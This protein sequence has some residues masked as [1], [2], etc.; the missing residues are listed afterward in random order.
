MTTIKNAIPLSTDLGTTLFTSVAANTLVTPVTPM[1]PDLSSK[2]DTGRSNLDNI[3]NA[4]ALTFSGKA[5]SKA[6][7]HLLVNGKDV[8]ALTG[9]QI[10]ADANGAWSFTD[11]KGTV[12]QNNNV[13]Q[14]NTMTEIAGSMS[15][16]SPTLKVTVDRQKPVLKVADLV[17]A[18]DSGFSSSDD[19]TN[20]VATTFTGVSEAGAVVNLYEMVA[21]K[22]N[23]ISLASVTA[24]ANGIWTAKLDGKM[25]LSEGT[26]QIVT[27]STDV[28]G[29]VSDFSPALKLSIDRT[30]PATLLAPQLDASAQVPNASNTTWQSQPVFSGKAQA[31]D[32]ITLIDVDNGSLLGKAIVQA[33][34]AWKIQSSALSL[35][36]HHLVAYATDLAG[37]VSS[38]SEMSTIQVSAP[39]L[40]A[41]STPA[42]MAKYDSGISQ[43]DNITNFNQLFF[44]A[45][46]APG[47]TVR[48]YES[49][50][51]GEIEIGVD[52]ANSFGEVDIYSTVL[53]EGKHIIYARS[54]DGKQ[55]STKSDSMVMTVDTKVSDFSLRMDAASDNGKSNSDGIT[56]VAQPT[57]SGT[58][59]AY[60]YVEL[61]E[62]L[63]KGQTVSLGQTKADA[64][65]NWSLTPSVPLAHGV[66]H[67]TG[68]ATDVAGNTTLAS[69]DIELKLYDLKVYVDLN[70]NFDSGVSNQDHVTNSSLLQFDGVTNPGNMVI[71]KNSSQYWEVQ[72]DKNGYWNVKADNLAEGVHEF[73]TIVYDEAGNGGNGAP[74]KVEVDRTAP[75]VYVFEPSSK[76]NQVWL[77]GKAD[78]TSLVEVYDAQNNILLDKVSTNQYGEWNVSLQGVSNGTLHLV[79]KQTDLAG[80]L[81][82]SEMVKVVVD[83]S[84]AGKLAQ[85]AAVTGQEFSAQTHAQ[86]AMVISSDNAAWHDDAVSLVGVQHL[87]P[88]LFVM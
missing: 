50:Q 64:S 86:S 48:L 51:F 74:M 38:K 16:M 83:N 9:S 61:F 26:H 60:G 19:I 34:G 17:A 15:K 65:G 6:L 77:A 85:F 20:A 28:A 53:G 73:Y 78:G 35:G 49:T 12:F 1:Q 45:K 4:S 13:Y 23:Y 44:E 67:I 18:S 40:G 7:I 46:S 33:D 29:N 58:L 22:A 25:S 8:S 11:T 27:R 43:S 69:Q 31:N 66:H 81:G 10:W 55:V 41:P 5:E 32:L 84:A 87:T 57:F 80:N 24:N 70:K 59:E 68:R 39:V 14:V 21:G 63:G 52:K 36:N 88:E 47:S 3:T 42:L 62:D 79:A 56:N 37:N 76:G 75:N 72:A 2:T 71:M 30:A 82:K 54:E